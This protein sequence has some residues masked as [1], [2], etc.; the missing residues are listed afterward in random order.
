MAGLDDGAAERD[1]EVRLADAGR[2]EEQDVL[3]PAMKRPVASSRTSFA[4]DGRLELEVELLERLHRR[5]V[6]DLDAHG[7]ALALLGVDLLAQQLVEEVEVGRLG[8]RGLGQDRVEALGHV[9]EAQPDQVLVDT[10]VDEFG[11][12]RTASSAS[13]TA[14]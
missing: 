8:A 11:S 1:G 9:A 14:A 5:E 10:G 6:G 4:V 3:A 2:A 13:T 12:C 7:D